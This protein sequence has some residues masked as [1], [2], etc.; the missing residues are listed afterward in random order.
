[1]FDTLDAG[2]IWAIA[3]VVL[4]IAELLAPGFFLFFIGVAAIATGAFTL[5]FDLGTAPQLVLFAI[6]TG[7]ALLIGKRYY[8]QPDTADQN[9]HLN[10]PGKRL[11]GRSVIV[12]DPVDQHGGRVRVGDSEWT[13]RGGPAAAGERVTI[14]GVDGNCLTVEPMPALPSE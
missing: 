4:L 7:L 9:V 13:A 14:T 10:E 1:M 3:G 8:A 5:M 11:I 12:V 2:W 6:Y